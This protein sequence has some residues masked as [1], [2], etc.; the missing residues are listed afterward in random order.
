MQLPFKAICIDSSNKP[1]DIPLSKW[2]KKESVYTIYQI[3]R[4]H[5]QGGMLGCKIEE[6]NI[7]DC[8]PYSYFALSRFKPVIDIEMEE[9]VNKEIDELVA[10]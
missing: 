3:D 5:L 4:L 1:P 8:I 9:N 2:I 7:D 6:V 10:V